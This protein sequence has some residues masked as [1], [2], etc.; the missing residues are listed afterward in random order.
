MTDTTRPTVSR[1]LIDRVDE[2]LR[3]QTGVPVDNLGFEA[4]IEALLANVDAEA[5]DGDGEPTVHPEVA[6]RIK[7]LE[8]VADRLGAR[9][10]ELDS[11]LAAV[12]TAGGG[13]KP[14]ETG[15]RRAPME[16]GDATLPLVT[17]Q[18]PAA[19]PARDDDGDDSDLVM[20][21]DGQIRERPTRQDLNRR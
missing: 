1:E 11:R 16:N 6:H 3:E 15:G 7:Q 14:T 2:T 4:K 10:D 8:G 9:V 5:D 12:A 17:G 13:D 20:M 19:T 18:T 21:E